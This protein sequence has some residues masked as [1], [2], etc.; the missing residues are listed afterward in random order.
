V[1]FYF[2][3]L[4]MFRSI[5]HA[6]AWGLLPVVLAACGSSPDKSDSSS[7]PEVPSKYTHAYVSPISVTL[8][9]KDPDDNRVQ[10]KRAFEKSLPGV[11]QEALKESGL[12][13]LSEQ[14]GQREG[15]VVVQAKLSYDPGNRALRWVGGIVG[16][17]KATVD[18][19]LEATDA[20]SGKVVASKQE[21]DSKRGGAFGG[22][23]YED[24]AETLGEATEELEEALALI[25]R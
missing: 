18:I 8:L 6:A 16:A 7:V 25:K 22:D 10:D 1:L 5:V 3:E 2:R 20:S 14:P 13:V 9:D 11:I 23:F 12:E 17:G 21:S 19:S 4:L 24:A 15:A